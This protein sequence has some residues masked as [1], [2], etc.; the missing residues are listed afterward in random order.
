MV[1][2]GTTTPIV[3][4][5]AIIDDDE[6]AVE[7][8]KLELLE[9]EFEPVPIDKGSFRGIQELVSLISTIADGAICDHRLGWAGFADFYGANLVALL[10]DRKLP[11]ILVTQYVDIDED[12]SIRRWRRKIPVLLSRDKTSSSVI[13]EGLTSCLLEFGGR[14]PH[15]RIPHRSMIRI[16]GV[17]SESGEKVVDVIVP[18]WNPTRA[19]RFP[20]SIIT[21]ELHSQ[22]KPGQRLIA[23]VNIGAEKSEDLY[24]DEFELA[25]L[26]E[27]NDGLA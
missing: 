4:K 19:V 15:N 8:A 9:A 6:N 23:Y 7:M 16:T 1:T 3:K 22:I 10:Y 17:S 21:P 27:E 25:P 11:A 12:V 20:V 5:V 14:I 26:P 13:K 24:F 18:S 2:L